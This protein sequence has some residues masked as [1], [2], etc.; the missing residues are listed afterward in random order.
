MNV[1]IDTTYKVILVLI[2]IAL[3][4]TLG[5]AIRSMRSAVTLQFY[6]KK[7]DMLAY[8][9]R[10]IFLSIILGGIGFFFFKFAEPVAY[11]YFHLLQLSPEHRPLP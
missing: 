7:R 10:M 8:G 2:A 11:R 5:M 6:R 1:D 9:W 4:S 3:V